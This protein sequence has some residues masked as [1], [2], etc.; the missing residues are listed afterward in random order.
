MDKHKHLILVVDDNNNFREIISLKL[1]SLGHEIVEAVDGKD[2]LK[3]LEKIN[4]DIILLDLDMP[5]MNGMETLEEIKKNPKHKD[6]KI[7]FL[8]NY[9]DIEEK[10]KE[11]DL[12]IA[13]ELGAF[14]YIR[15][16]DDLSEIIKEFERVVH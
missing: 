6:T 1:K 11:F 13:N 10:G 3:K 9:G 14:H 4:P 12:K 5:I 7:I 2:G 8:T 16:G 15:K